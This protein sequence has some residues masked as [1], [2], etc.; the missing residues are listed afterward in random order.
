[1]T[2]PRYLRIAGDTVSAADMK[3][4]MSRVTD[5]KFHLFRPGGIF[6]LNV[7]IKIAR[8]FSSAKTKLYPAWQGMQYMRD[9]MEGR[10]ELASHDN[11]RYPDM[12]WTSAEEFLV[13][14][15]VKSRV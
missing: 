15:D 11:A 14:E 10:A 8:F 3:E 1:M 13:S 7:I 5:K 4:I 2:T 12:R 6:L 9:M